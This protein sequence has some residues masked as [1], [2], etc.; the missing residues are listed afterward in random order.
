MTREYV[1]STLHAVPIKQFQ[2]IMKVM[3]IAFTA[4]LSSCCTYITKQDAVQIAK[5]EINRRSIRLP[6]QY[7]V[8]AERDTFIGESGLEIPF[9]V[10]SFN[11]ARGRGQIP[12][13]DVELDARNGGVRSV[14]DFRKSRV[15]RV[16][17]Y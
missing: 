5:A 1:S 8:D 16:G 10:V 7:T 9:Y 4:L 3:A 13:C 17:D 12:F 2:L 15:F 6:Q 11:I 14:G